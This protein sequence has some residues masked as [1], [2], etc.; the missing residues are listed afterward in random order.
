MQ[1]SN[2]RR[3]GF[4]AVSLVS[5]WVLAFSGYWAAI[6]LGNEFGGSIGF[7][8][9]WSGIGWV[10]L[11]LIPT[12]L[13][14]TSTENRINRKLERWVWIAGV[15]FVCACGCCYWLGEHDAERAFHS[16]PIAFD[17]AR[18]REAHAV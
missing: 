3:V 16:Q 4:T 9:Y 15:G 2:A 12:A 5:F 13:L 1:V 17:H 14:H 10:G 11:A 6:G 8:E 7:A 18:A